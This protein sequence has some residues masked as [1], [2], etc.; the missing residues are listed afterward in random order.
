MGDLMDALTTSDLHRWMQDFAAE[1]Q[2]AQDHLSELDAAAGDADHG[3]NL[4]RGLQAV[5][6]ALP[7][8]Q[9]PPG[10]VCK[11]FGLILVDTIGGSSGALYGTVFLRLA[12]AIGMTALEIP[13]PVLAHGFE[14]ASQGIT[15]RGGARRGD[16]T[17]L[18]AIGPAADALTAAVA[19]RTPL[20]SAL[21]LAAQ[22]AEGGAAATRSMQARR[23]KASYVGIRSIGTPD[24]GATSAA[25]LFRSLARCMACCI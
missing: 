15:D 21:V 7:E 18:D 17:M 3:S 6:A 20:P 5:L 24:P 4:T 23:G 10:R 11:E 16:K 8:L 22:A 12:Q 19:A 25:A 2:A 14:A 13:L 9:G 1:V